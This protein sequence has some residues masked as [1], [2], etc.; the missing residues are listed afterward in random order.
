MVELRVT[1]LAF[2]A[3]KWYM[4]MVHMA[5]EPSVLARE[6]RVSWVIIVVGEA[7]EC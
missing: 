2:T 6:Y 7:K 4:T 3:I 5:R 1:Y